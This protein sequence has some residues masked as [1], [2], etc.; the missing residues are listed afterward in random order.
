MPEISKLLP[1]P[2][3]SESHPVVTSLPPG[4]GRETRRGVANEQIGAELQVAQQLSNR[5]EGALS[6]YVTDNSD[7]GASLGGSAAG[8]CDNS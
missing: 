3:T 1:W 7:R 4:T 5:G 6:I 2:F 8:S